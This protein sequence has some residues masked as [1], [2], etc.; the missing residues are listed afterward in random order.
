MIVQ[1]AGFH[2][3]ICI[4]LISYFVFKM[5]RFY[6]IVFDI[7]PNAFAREFPALPSVLV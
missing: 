3:F 4:I 6:D 5:R 2:L 7:M 1:M